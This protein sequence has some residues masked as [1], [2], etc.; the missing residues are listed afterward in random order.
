MLTDAH[1]KT[2][3][4]QPPAPAAVAFPHFISRLHVLHCP[5]LSQRP[6]ERHY[7]GGETAVVY[8]CHTVKRHTHTHTEERLLLLQL[9]PS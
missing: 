1:R 5:D 2:K 4:T 8:Q 6:I 3:K 7:D 9:E